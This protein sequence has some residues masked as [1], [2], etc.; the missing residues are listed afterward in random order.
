MEKKRKLKDFV[1]IVCLE[2]S[3]KANPLPE[4]MDVLTISVRP[5]IFQL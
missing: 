3:Q 2:I 1:E 4:N 5:C